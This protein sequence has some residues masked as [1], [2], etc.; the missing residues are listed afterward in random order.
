MDCQTFFL[1]QY[2]S[3]HFDSFTNQTTSQQTPTPDNSPSKNL[4]YS[5]VEQDSFIFSPTFWQMKRC[6]VFSPSPRGFKFWHLVRHKVAVSIKNVT[7]R[8]KR[9]KHTN[10]S[11][12]ERQAKITGLFKIKKSLHNFYIY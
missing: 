4:S 11:T 9:H 7:T 6:K 8:S 3:S 5:K 2:L 10:K 12:V 1:D